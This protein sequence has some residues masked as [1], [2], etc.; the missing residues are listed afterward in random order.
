M[1]LLSVHLSRVFPQPNPIPF[2][3]SVARFSNKC[4]LAPLAESLPVGMGSLRL[5]SALARTIG[6]VIVSAVITECLY[7]MLIMM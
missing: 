3:A 2:P 6:T 4:C 5:S 1:Y 7:Y